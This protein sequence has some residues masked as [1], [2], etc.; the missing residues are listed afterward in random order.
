MNYPKPYILKAGEPYMPTYLYVPEY[1]F[2]LEQERTGIEIN[3]HYFEGVDGFNT[4]N[5]GSFA[6]GGRELEPSEPIEILIRNT[7]DHIRECEILNSYKNKL[8]ANYGNPDKIEVMTSGNSMASYVDEL[9]KSEHT[10]K[11]IGMISV[12]VI[13]KPNDITFQQVMNQL[14]LRH[15]TMN[16]AGIERIRS[17][18]TKYDHR[19]SDISV[20]QNNIPAGMVRINGFGGFTAVLMQRT[21]ILLKFYPAAEQSREPIQLHPD[22]LRAMREQRIEARLDVRIAKAQAKANRK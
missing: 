13:D 2:E 21:T 14:T 6:D 1:R 11:E 8:A 18:G 5:D 22:Q 20:I 17:I 16:P 15:V 12:H 3:G 10:N 9:M 19:Q 4:F 7:S